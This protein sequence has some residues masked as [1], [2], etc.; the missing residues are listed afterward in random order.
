VPFKG[1]YPS[2]SVCWSYS[3]FPELPPGWFQLLTQLPETL[4]LMTLVFDKT[5]KALW[6]VKIAS[7]MDDPKDVM[8]LTVTFMS[9]PEG[10]NH[11]SNLVIDGVSKQLNIAIQNLNYKHV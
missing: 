10:T 1:P 3:G 7:Y 9:L 6:Q 2:C 8:N 11:V 5:Q 4:D